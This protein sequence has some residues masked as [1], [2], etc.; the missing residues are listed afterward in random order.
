[1]ELSL[2][3]MMGKN[4]QAGVTVL[5]CLDTYLGNCHVTVENFDLIGRKTPNIVI[6]DITDK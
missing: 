5:G 6:H 1:M 4:S 3:M 2:L